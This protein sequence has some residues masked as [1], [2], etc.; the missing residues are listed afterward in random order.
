M[1]QIVAQRRNGGAQRGAKRKSG[2]F[3]GGLLAACTT[4][5]YTAAVCAVEFERPGGIRTRVSAA[6]LQSWTVGYHRTQ[7]AITC[8]PVFYPLNYRP[9]CEHKPL[10]IGLLDIRSSSKTP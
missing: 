9:E 8:T 3:F 10:L 6:C 2:A 1:S 5:F 7:G 4:E